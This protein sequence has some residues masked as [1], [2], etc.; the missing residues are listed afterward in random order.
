MNLLCIFWAFRRCRQAKLATAHQAQC[1]DPSGRI[2]LTQSLHSL[3]E[4]SG[5]EGLFRSDCFDVLMQGN[6]MSGQLG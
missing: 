2:S 4:P 5:S 1:L 3:S 6:T